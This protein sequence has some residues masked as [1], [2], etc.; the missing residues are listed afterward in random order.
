MNANERELKTRISHEFTRMNTNQ[1]QDQKQ[2]TNQK[3]NQS[4]ADL[5]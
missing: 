1:K 3:Q 4:A 5:R 2:E